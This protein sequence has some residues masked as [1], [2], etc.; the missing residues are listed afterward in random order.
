MKIM[1]IFVSSIFL[2]LAAFQVSCL[3][4]HQTKEASSTVLPIYTYKIDSVNLQY[5]D[6]FLGGTITLDNGYILKIVDYKSRDDNAMTSWQSGDA[7]W[8]DAESRDNQIVMV[9][10][11]EQNK[12]KYKAQPYVIFDLLESS[13]KGPKVVNVT[14]DGQYV[15]LSDGSVWQF[16]WWNKLSTKH[17]TPDQRVLVQGHGE[18][19]EYKFINVDVTPDFINYDKATGS[20]VVQ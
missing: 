20:Y 2:S 4:A 11:N 19:N 16:G 10:S 17:W 14:H 1:N 6:S 9:V 15:K 8:L 18:K 13:N 7:L 12:D 5:E 3:A